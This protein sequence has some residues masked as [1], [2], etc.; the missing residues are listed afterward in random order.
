VENAF[1]LAILACGLLAFY[2][3]TLRGLRKHQKASKKSQ[4]LRAEK[5]VDALYLGEASPF[6]ISRSYRDEH[7]IQ[8]EEYTYGEVM[9]QTLAKLLEYVQPKPGEIFYDLGCGAGKALFSTALY[10]PYLQIKGIELLPPLYELCIKL[11]KRFDQLVSKDIVFS[12]LIFNIDFIPGDFLSADFSD[13]TIFFLNATC[14]ADN[15]WLNLQKKLLQLSIG[16]RLIIVTRRLENE[17][18][19]LIEGATYTMSWGP[20]SVCVY[21]KIS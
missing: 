11:K 14:L 1:V 13:G 6:Q 10:Y 16:T 17:A 18:F 3:L 21:R 4:M 7:N 9:V 15:D 5:L 19:Q 20:S 12:N 2:Q 8:G